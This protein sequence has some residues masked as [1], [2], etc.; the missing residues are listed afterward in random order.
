MKPNEKHSFPPF[1]CVVEGNYLEV[2]KEIHNGHLYYLNTKQKALIFAYCVVGNCPT[3]P[4]ATVKKQGKNVE[5]F[6]VDHDL[7]RTL[8]ELVNF[9]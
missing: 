7:H 3:L 8:S 1:H 5:M 4:T 2:L 6:I 9:E